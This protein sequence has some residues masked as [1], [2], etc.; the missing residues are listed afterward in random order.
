MI[1][2]KAELV[3]DVINRKNTTYLPSQI[4]FANLEKD[5]MCKLYWYK[6]GR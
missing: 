5:G 6:N 1:K 4:T 2:N 3:M